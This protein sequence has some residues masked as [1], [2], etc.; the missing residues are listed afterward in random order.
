MGHILRF[1]K[2]FFD[3]CIA[4]NSGRSHWDGGTHNW[5]SST[6]ARAVGLPTF[7]LSILLAYYLGFSLKS[8]NVS[9]SSSLYLYLWYGFSVGLEA[10]KSIFQCWFLNC[11][12]I[13]H[14]FIDTVVCAS[15]S[16][17]AGDFNCFRVCFS[18]SQ[19]CTNMDIL[20]FPLPSLKHASTEL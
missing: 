10:D 5:A 20:S 1:S 11:F 9:S 16:S 4:V 3:L 13:Q 14:F 18:P 15:C 17:A 2:A 12:L 7:Y 19:H 8:K 6:K